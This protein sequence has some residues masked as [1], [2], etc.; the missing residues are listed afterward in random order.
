MFTLIKGYLNYIFIAVVV[1]LL[2]AC[3]YL[4]A[5]K[6]S[7]EKDLT[8]AESKLEAALKTIKTEKDNNKI[9]TSENAAKVSELE[10]LTKL[11]QEVSLKV[12]EVVRQKNELQKRLDRYLTT[13]PTTIPRGKVAE[14][15]E[16]YNNSLQRITVLWASYCEENPSDP[17]CVAILKAKGEKP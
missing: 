8:V 13:L 4:Y 10:A 3:A 9:L 12:T 16:E 5:S 1:I 6:A 2:L 15:Q 11:N 17:A 14:T 7:V